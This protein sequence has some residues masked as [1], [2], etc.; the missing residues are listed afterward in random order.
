MMNNEQKIRF[1]EDMRLLMNYMT[2]MSDQVR[3]ELVT[4]S[5]ESRRWELGVCSCSMRGKAQAAIIYSVLS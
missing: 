2:R 3:H 4:G 1:M 5:T